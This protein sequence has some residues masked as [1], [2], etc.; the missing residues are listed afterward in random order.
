MLKKENFTQIG[1]ILRSHTLT[2]ECVAKLSIELDCIDQDTNRL[3]LLIDI[4]DCL[5][6][7]RVE[8]YRYKSLDNV[9]LSFY[10]VC[11][12]D[13]ADRIVNKT[14]WIE[15]NLIPNILDIDNRTITS[16]FCGFRL[17]NSIDNK[18][19]GHIENI[20]T[21]TINTLAKVIIDNNREVLIPIASEL[22]TDIDREEK[23]IYL[24]VPEGLLS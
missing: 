10:D 23:A 8:E 14:L 6:P 13:E 2:G 16:T 20:D 19:I 12:K 9:F 11:S 24:N 21:S 1:Y 7:F 3:F 5:I 17:Y 22:I 15:N 18:Y 4:D